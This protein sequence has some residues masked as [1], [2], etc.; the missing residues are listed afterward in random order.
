MPITDY[1]SKDP[2]KRARFIFDLIAPIYGKIEKHQAEKYV[3]T[4]KV[5][6]KE[7]GIA[8]K[9]VLDVG[10]GTGAW[11]DMFVGMQAKEVHAVDLSPKM[12]EEARKK[13]PEITFER[14]DA[15]NLTEIADKSFDIVTASFVLHG[16]KED[17]RRKILSEMKR[18]SREFVVI[19]DF[20]GRTDLAI[21]I[22]E[23]LER[24]DYKKFK[25]NFC[26]ELKSMFPD[27]RKVETDK[28]NAL[29]LALTEKD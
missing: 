23:T 24:S 26:N 19:N 5:L 27:V 1:F 28:G 13:H 12:L 14:G 9:T 3:R 22:L 6:D 17:R 10:T 7:I 8:G 16:V 21:Y 2:N 15:E 11:A 20:S 4:I 25:A 29:Y 18:I